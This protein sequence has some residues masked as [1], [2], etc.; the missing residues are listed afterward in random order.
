MKSIAALHCL[1]LLAAAGARR[2][3]GS[4][5]NIL[6][7][8]ADDLG[9]NDLTSYGSPTIETP[10]IDQIGRNGARFT[11]FY[12]GAPVCTPSR[13]SMLTGRL[14]VRSG[15]FSDLQAPADELFRVFYPTSVGCLPSSEITVAEALKPVYSTAMIG[16][17]LNVSNALYLFINS[18]ILLLTLGIWAT[19]KTRTVF[20]EPVTKDSTP[21]MVSPTVTRKGIPGPCRRGWSSL[22][23]L[24]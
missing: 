6:L 12:T 11:Q 13:S 8:V 22:P 23:F 10:N 18:L 16:K 5:V 2:S 19:T 7:I 17:W 9:Y 20:P 4:P 14:P 15:I 3:G 21:F 24:S 1:L